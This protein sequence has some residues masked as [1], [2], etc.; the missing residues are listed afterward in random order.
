MDKTDAPDLEV[1]YQQEGVIS[2][3]V[4]A[5]FDVALDVLGQKNFRLIT[6]AENAEL[7]LKA[8]HGSRIREYGNFVD[9]WV[10]YCPKAWFNHKDGGAKFGLGGKVRNFLNSG[11]RINV[12]DAMNHFRSGAEVEYYPDDETIGEFLKKAVTFPDESLPTSSQ[13]GVKSDYLTGDSELIVHMLG[14]G[15]ATKASEYD[16][17][18]RKPCAGASAGAF[19]IH[20]WVL[21]RNSY[22]DRQIEK[23][24][25]GAKT[26]VPAH[27]RPFVRPV[28]FSG[29]Q[30]CSL[31]DVMRRPEKSARVRGI[32][33]Y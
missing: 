28:Y 32:G 18:N 21:P 25:N 12:A 29:I 27:L 2:A 10:M 5:P 17:L 33:R 20:A 15:D 14:G 3:V 23:E 16:M 26:T 11:V 31:I 13:G 9:A 4:T 1:D 7:R 6:P 30:V 24:V 22:A 8:E 19:G